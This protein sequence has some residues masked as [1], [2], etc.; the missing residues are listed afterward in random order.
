VNQFLQ[1]HK[2]YIISTAKVTAMK[3][4]LLRNTQ[5]NQSAKGSRKY[6]LFKIAWGVC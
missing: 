3:E 6:C 2:S 5:N 1:V 4:H